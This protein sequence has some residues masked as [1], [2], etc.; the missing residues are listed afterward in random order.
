MNNDSKFEALFQNTKRIWLI[1]TVIA[2]LGLL[3]I[4][5]GN[6][7]FEI[8]QQLSL[9]LIFLTLI[10]SLYSLWLFLHYISGMVWGI[11]SSINPVLTIIAVVLFP[12]LIIPIYIGWSAEQKLYDS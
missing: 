6:S 4:I 5:L 10:T 8:S 3:L 1:S 12:P 2:I 7:F 9:V 11:A